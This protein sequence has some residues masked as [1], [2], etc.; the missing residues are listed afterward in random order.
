MDSF[1]E[2]QNTIQQVLPIVL[3]GPG[4]VLVATGLFMWL[5]GLRWLK[6]VAA[7]SA[8]TAGLLCA[9][10]FTDRQLVA[11]ILFPVILAGLG[12]YFNKIVVVVLGALIA[13]MLVLF[14][15]VVMGFDDPKAA[16]GMSGTEERF[17]LL[18]SVEWILAKIEAVKQSIK[19]M[20][21]SIPKPRKMTAIAV[22]VII[23]IIGLF[24]RRLVCA[25]TCSVIGTLLI[26]CGMMLLLLYKGSEPVTK[27]YDGR[28]LYALVA[29]VMAVVGVVLQLC[30]CPA[31]QKKA[32]LAKEVLNE[33]DK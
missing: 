12:M 3:I 2:I 11:I 10:F 21:E 13:A 33:G 6:T 19:E 8:A 7:F 4:L 22:A 18:E 23:V 30:L 28:Q 15:P 32:D 9:W 27:I 20:A 29:V 5:G 24:A 16:S 25:M 31:K 26:F 17:D 1:E 14:V